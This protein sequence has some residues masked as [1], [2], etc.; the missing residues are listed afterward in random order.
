MALLPVLDILNQLI[1]VNN[2]LMASQAVT[3]P[4]QI[5]NDPVH[6]DT[7]QDFLRWQEDIWQEYY[8]GLVNAQIL[9]QAYEIN[10]LY[11]LNAVTQ[12]EV[13]SILFEE[14]EATPRAILVGDDV[15]SL[16]SRGQPL[17]DSLKTIADGIR[18]ADK[19]KIAQIEAIVKQLNDQFDQDEQK[20]SQDSID[21]A[22][23]I[24]ATVIE[25]GVDVATEE[26]PIAPLLKGVTQVGFTVIDQ[27]VLS[28]EAKQILGQL[29]TEWAALDAATADLAQMN[30]VINQLDAVVQDEST[31]FKALASIASDWQSVADVANDDPANW[32][33]TGNTAMQEWSERMARVSYAAATQTV[34]AKELEDA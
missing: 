18:D 9:A 2:Y 10:K 25:V 34:G 7:V 24:V 22:K 5:K 33:A 32:A 28:Q 17:L 3:L 21:N 14:G 6:Q 27:I 19:A 23:Q 4:S 16:I 15:A 11:G 29:E 31:A 30:L 12:G 8:E 26:D 20:I 13:Q 1:T